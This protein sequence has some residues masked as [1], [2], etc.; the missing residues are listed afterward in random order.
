MDGMIL[1]NTHNNS[2]GNRRI[3]A[4]E[5]RLTKLEADSRVTRDDLR[6]A[7]ERLCKLE[8]YADHHI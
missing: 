1:D 4:L 3:D 6:A 2:D 5:R 7:F 8:T